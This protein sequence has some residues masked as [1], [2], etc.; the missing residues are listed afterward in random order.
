[1]PG[2]LDNPVRLDPWQRI[3]EVGWSTGIEIIFGV[4]G[5]ATVPEEENVF[6]LP[7]FINGAEGTIEP[8]IATIHRKYFKVIV[9]KRAE[10]PGIRSVRFSFA[11]P[12]II[13][14]DPEAF[15]LFLEIQPFIGT[16][17]L[18]PDFLAQTCYG[19][20]EV[21]ITPTNDISVPPDGYSTG[22]VVTLA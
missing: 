19:F 7:T 3:T 17:G 12:V 22:L 5:G 10:P 1:M 11:A 6:G 21:L 4:D 15:P 14:G 16:T 8:T 2:S 13:G 20:V 9:K 18:S